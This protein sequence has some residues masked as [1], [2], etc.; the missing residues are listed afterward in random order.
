MRGLKG[1]FVGLIQKKFYARIPR[2]ICGI[3]LEKNS[4]VLPMRCYIRNLLQIFEKYAR[5]DDELYSVVLSWLVASLLGCYQSVRVRPS[6]EARK[7]IYR[8]FFF[9]NMS[10]DKVMEWLNPSK[11]YDMDRDE[12]LSTY[13]KVNPNAFKTAAP[14]KDA[15]EKKGRKPRPT[16]KKRPKTKT[17]KGRNK[18]NDKR[19]S[20]RAKKSKRETAE[21]PKEDVNENLTPSNTTR[22]SSSVTNV[23]PL[24]TSSFSSPSYSRIPRAASLNKKVLKDFSS[25][26]EDNN[27]G[28]DSD[29]EGSNKKRKRNKE[30]REH[31]PDSDSSSYSSRSSSS[32]RREHRH[33][34]HLRLIITAATIVTVIRIHL[35]M[36][37]ATMRMK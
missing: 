7:M 36:M 18:N 26:D 33:H 3:Y 23:P 2:K 16:A 15:R 14:D 20:T 13:K 19:K 12:M 29:Y 10:K 28:S 25:S 11:L 8:M 32:R 17:K 9:Y 21:D 6:L 30:K 5:Q 24:P 34:H 1:K 22:A 31:E 37:I 4:K 27:G 35:P